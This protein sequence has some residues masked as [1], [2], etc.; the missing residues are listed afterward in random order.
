MNN[1]L[2]FLELCKESVL[3]QR[4]QIFEFDVDWIDPG[5]HALIEIACK[6]GSATIEWHEDTGFTL[7]IVSPTSSYFEAR[8]G[9]V[10]GDEMFSR[11]SLLW[12]E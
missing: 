3:S 2:K 9:V 1:L 10:S 12:F 5:S 11:I 7:R 6:H 4:N 8:Q